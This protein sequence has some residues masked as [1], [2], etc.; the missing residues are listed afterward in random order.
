MIKEGEAAEL[1][2]IKSISEVR[3]NQSNL[4]V[5]EVLGNE[6]YIG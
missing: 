2:S 4:K 1:S 3:I 5:E 6:S